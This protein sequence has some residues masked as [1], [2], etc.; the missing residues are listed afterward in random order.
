MDKKRHLKKKKKY[1]TDNIYFSLN[2][3]LNRKNIARNLKLHYIIS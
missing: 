1:Y 3:L 2:K